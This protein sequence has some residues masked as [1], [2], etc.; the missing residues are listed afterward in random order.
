MTLLPDWRAFIELLN[1]QEV[2]YVIVL[3][4]EVIDTICGLTLYK[5]R[6]SPIWTHS[7][8]P[9]CTRSPDLQSA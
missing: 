3:G 5:L 8:T 7:Q 2:D 6:T 9:K 4:R 1:A